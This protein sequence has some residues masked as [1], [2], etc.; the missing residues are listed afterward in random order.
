M[1]QIYLLFSLLIALHT[2][3]AP[4]TVPAS[5]LSFNTIEGGYFNIGW[6][7]GNGTRRIMIVRA[8]QAV[9]AVPQNGVDYTENT[10][11]GSGQAIAPGQYV[12]YDNA[13]TSFF[14]TGLSPATQYFFAI[15]EYNGTGAV[16]E[17][18]TSSFLSG[19]AFTVA[20]PTVQAGNMVF[21]NVTATSVT[22][23]FTAGNG[24]RRLL[25]AREGSAVNSDPV[26]LQQ[27]VGN[28]AFES[29]AQV[30][31][32]NYAVYSSTNTSVVVTNLKAATKYFFS[33]YEYNG[34][35]QPM[36]KTPGSTAN[37]TTR[38]IPTIPSSNIIVTK[39]D[40]KELSLS[41]TIGNG[42]RRIIV[43]KQGAA[44]TGS[45]ANGTDYTANEVF[46][47]GSTIT[48]GEFVVYSGTGNAAI[49]KGLNP[50]T[51]YHF[52]I[53]EY[54]GTG[55]NTL[56]LT[57]LFAAANG[58]T[59]ATPTA[60]A[61]GIAATNVLATTLNLSWLAGNG[62]ARLVVI[63][64]DAAVNITPQD[65]TVYTAN[66]DYGAGQQVGSGNFIL[67]NTADLFTTVHNLQPS[68]TYHFAVFEFNGF[69]QP[70]Y[71]SPAVVFSVTTLGPVPVKLTEWDAFLI[72]SK[73]E[74]EW[75]TASEENASHF[76]IQRSRDG[77]H[78][79]TMAS[80]PA[81][82]NSQVPVNY[83][84]E[85]ASPLQGSSFYRLQMVDKD[86]SFAYSRIVNI[87]FHDQEN[88]FY[89]LQNPVQNNLTVRLTAGTNGQNPE[90]RII[91]ASGQLLKKGNARSNRLDLNVA[92]LSPGVYCLQV[93]QKGKLNMKQFVKQ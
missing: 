6:T 13:F 77:V 60:Q 81:T 51:V 69:N 78:F 5:N 31:T 59:A 66:N 91:S 55:I 2:N 21:S 64:K 93:K 38:T 39:T 47:N 33:I 32:G 40:G 57:N 45:P 22:I 65:F 75:R 18:L 24:T 25:V 28:S 35:G 30:G 29:G 14:L 15:Y 20:A 68:T 85:D 58:T 84:M 44:I 4:P 71:L 88:E 12:V 49:I 83:H 42:Q 67:S 8:G 37:I 90:W 26:N 72:G 19:N 86:G 70:L 10:N 46:G 36:Y 73:V 27:Y 61:S 16:I 54:D 63:R 11:F 79:E 1:K 92:D 9:T 80:L 43:A 48:A 50:A 62:R 7:P 76:N 23:N 74:L 87:S 17:Y 56:F 89:I 52:R 53:F 41:W 34:N 82:G 3:A